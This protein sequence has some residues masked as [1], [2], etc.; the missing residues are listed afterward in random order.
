VVRSFY[1]RLSRFDL[2]AV[3]AMFE[4]MQSEA[5]AVVAQASLGATTTEERVAYMRYLGQGHEIAVPLP[6]RR[7]GQQDVAALRT[8]YETEY[9]KFYDRL[10]PGADIEVLAYAVKVATMPV[11]A[12][13]LRPQGGEA[14]AAPRRRKVRDVPNGTVSDWMI[15]D[16][17]GLSVDATLAGPAII[18]ESETSTL[19]GTGWIASLDSNGFIHLNREVR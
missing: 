3:N 1:Q 15:C 6:V 9:T 10:V 2:A 18:A 13:D 8:A 14:T 12:G 16:R 19:V 4:E 17:D 5:D 7:L 11:A